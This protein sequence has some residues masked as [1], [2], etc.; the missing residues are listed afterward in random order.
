MRKR[1]EQAL[2]KA[3]NAAGETWLST[4]PRFKNA[5]VIIEAELNAAVNE[6]RS[7]VPPPDE[8]HRD[9]YNEG[10]KEEREK[11]KELELVARNML[12]VFTGKIAFHATGGAVRQN[13][14]DALAAL[15]TEEK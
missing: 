10:V 2:N 9:G 6:Y 15:L 3:L 7:K 11:R 13:A 12:Y 5:V 1:A 4:G 14:Y 8:I